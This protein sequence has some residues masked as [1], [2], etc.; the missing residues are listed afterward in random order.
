MQIAPVKNLTKIYLDCFKND[1]AF[2]LIIPT[3]CEAFY[4]NCVVKETPKS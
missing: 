4:K 3:F 1:Q 2:L